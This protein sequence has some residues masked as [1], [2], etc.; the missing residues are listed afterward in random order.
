MPRY[1]DEQIVAY[2]DKD[3]SVALIA[4]VAAGGSIAVSAWDGL[5]WIVTDTVVASGAVEVYVG[6]VRFK[7]EPTVGTAYF[8]RGPK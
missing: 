4:N 1:T 5:E 3:E 7:F 8:V 2:T 6:G